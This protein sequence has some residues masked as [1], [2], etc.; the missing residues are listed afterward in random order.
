MVV[1]LK[2]A[3]VRVSFI[4][5]M[6]IRVQNKSKSVWK[7]RYDGDVSLFIHR[8]LPPAS[9]G[10]CSST[11]NRL[12]CGSLLGVLFIQ[13]VPPT[14]TGTCSSNPHQLGGAYKRAA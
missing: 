10:Y 11:P 8:R 9:T 13:W 4:Q 2:T 3:S 5:I 1:L 14:T 12:G 7:S 6:Q